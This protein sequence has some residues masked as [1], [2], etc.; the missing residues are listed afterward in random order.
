LSYD[1]SASGGD[2]SGTGATVVWAAPEETGVYVLTVTVGDGYGSSA[3]DSLSISVATGEPPNI[4]TLLVTAEHCYL[5]A[6]SW[7]YRVGKEQEYDIECVVSDPTGGLSYEWSYTGGEISEISQDGSAITWIAPDESIH[8][9]VAVVVSDIV[10][11]MVGESIVLEVVACSP[12]TF[13]C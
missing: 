6:H 1:W 3:T 10:G 7:G 2:I 12:C 9:T 5:Q 8:I 11:N 4:E 13:G